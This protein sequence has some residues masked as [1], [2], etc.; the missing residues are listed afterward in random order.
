ME[1]NSITLPSGMRSNLIALQKTAQA[2]GIAQNRL[3]TGKK[4]NNAIDDPMAFFTAELHRQRASDLTA[5]KDEMAEAIQT[6]HAANNG[7]EGI[8]TLVVSAQSLAQAARATASTTERAALASQFNALLTQIDSLARD[9]GYKGINLLG[10]DGQNLEVAFD[11]SGDSSVTVAGFD[12]THA[13]LGI[14]QMIMGT[15]TGQAG[16]QSEVLHNGNPT[17]WVGTV[18]HEA[19][20]NVNDL[21]GENSTD[22]YQNNSLSFVVDV[23]GMETLDVWY[24]FYTREPI[25][26]YDRFQIQINGQPELTI[27]SGDYGDD[28]PSTVESSGWQHFSYDLTGYEEATLDLTINTGDTNDTLYPSWAYVDVGADGASGSSWATSEGITSSLDELDSALSSLRT[29]LKA[30]ASNL[31]TITT[32]QDFTTGLVNLLGDG[33]ANLT[34]ADLN[35]EGANVLM[36]GTRQSLAVN[37]LALAAQATQSVM[38]L[39]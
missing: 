5:R 37:S 36:L 7:I 12:A 32:R 24:N 8:A 25:A 3:A 1:L 34:T 26:T 30:L 20:L 13:G 15:T 16:L 27:Q 28:N 10:G 18:D 29:Q 6:I 2:M 14:S 11:E 31:S 38:R 19:P 22:N 21:T 35:E 39:F 4:V 33:A 9:S 23:A 17:Y